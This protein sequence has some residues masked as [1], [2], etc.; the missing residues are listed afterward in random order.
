MRQNKRHFRQAENTPLAGTEV[1]DK[2][3]FGAT[4]QLANEILEETANLDEITDDPTSKRLL[5]EFKTSQPELEIEV[6]KE[7]MMD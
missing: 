3:G 7:K 1:S 5:K 4:T 2:L 6:T